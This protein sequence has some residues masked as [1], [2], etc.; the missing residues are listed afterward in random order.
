MKRDKRL[1]A[2]CLLALLAFVAYGCTTMAEKRKQYLDSH[3]DIPPSFRQAIVQ[4]KVLKNMTHDMV[5]ATWGNPLQIE[6]PADTT[7]TD[8]IWIY[9][10]STEA[11]STCLCFKHGLVAYWEQPCSRALTKV[12]RTRPAGAQIKPI[13]DDRSPEP[14]AEPSKGDP[15]NPR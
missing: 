12:E 8:E 11:P 14:V 15:G 2:L 10:A 9:A 6:E 1:M 3:P 5:V 4:G 13:I 7:K